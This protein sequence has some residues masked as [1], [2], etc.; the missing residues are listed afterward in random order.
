MASRRPIVATSISSIKEI[1]EDDRNALLIDPDSSDSL[2]NGIKKVLE[3]PLFAEKIAHQA[4]SDARKYTWENRINKILN[5][6]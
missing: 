4:A 3:D 1:L 5:G 6:L 2:F